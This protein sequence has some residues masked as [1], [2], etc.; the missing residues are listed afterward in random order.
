MPMKV[1]AVAAAGEVHPNPF[2]GPVN[3]TAVVRADVSDLSSYEVDSLGYLKPGVFLTRA[4]QLVE[5]EA[6]LLTIATLA[7]SVTAEKFKTTTTSLSRIAG[8][9]VSKAAEDNLVFS[10]AHVI[11]LDKYGIIVIQ[12]N[13][14]GT[15]STLVPGATQTTP[16]TYATAALALAAK[17]EVADD[18]V[19]LGHIAIF[20]DGTAWTANTDDLTDASDVVTAAFVDATPT[21]AERNITRTYGVVVEAVQV[22]TGNTDALLDAA[23]DID[24]AIATICQVNRD[25]I[26]DCL[27]RALNSG[28]LNNSPDN[29]PLIILHPL[30]HDVCSFR[31]I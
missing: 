26:E 11:A 12:M 31:K 25:I 5:P 20:N 14:A 4:G 16:M 3:H 19:E 10:A 13:A 9:P 6:A 23:T 7:I 8:V 29:F 22:A 18:H 27:G 24:V 28:E 15:V 1:T 21:T 30:N 17:P 2:V